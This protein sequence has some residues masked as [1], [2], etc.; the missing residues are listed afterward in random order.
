M[1]RN[2]PNAQ[3]SLTRQE[4]TYQGKKQIQWT[5]SYLN[6]SG[7]TIL[8]SFNEKKYT[9]KKSGKQFV[10]AKAIN[11]GHAGERVRRNQMG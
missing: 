10:Y 7:E 8:I 3:F 2:Y 5:G 11:L 9:G 6:E 1:A 4:K